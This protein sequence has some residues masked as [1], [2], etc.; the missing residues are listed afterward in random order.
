MKFKK[1]NEN[2]ILSEAI[3]SSAPKWLRPAI[4]NSFKSKNSR[5]QFGSQGKS[6][7]PIL[8]SDCGRPP[9][10]WDAKAKSYL[11]RGIDI[12]SRLAKGMHFSGRQLWKSGNN[13]R[14]VL[15]DSDIDFS[16]A[17]FIHDEPPKN[18]ADQRLK[19]HDK[20]QS[21]ILLDFGEDTNGNKHEQIY[22]PGLN[23]KE[24]VNVSSWNHP[25]YDKTFS[26]V[27]YKQLKPYIKDFCY[28][29]MTDPNS[30][31]STVKDVRNA[32]GRIDAQ[33]GSNYINVR[34]DKP[35]LKKLYSPAWLPHGYDIDKSG[36]IIN[37]NRYKEILNKN[38]AK[39]YTKLLDELYDDLC[40]IKSEI[41]TLFTTVDI[42]GKKSSSS[43]LS[44]I[45]NLTYDFQDVSDYYNSLL[46]KIDSINNNT[47]NSEEE[48][49]EAIIGL[50]GTDADH[51]YGYGCYKPVRD[52]V[53]D[54][55]KKLNRYVSTIIDW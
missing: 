26:Y 48:K 20:Y 38:R 19:D 37:P 25:L 7:V 12:N 3:S 1:L 43:M 27:S 28:I 14:R 11:N 53:N 30:K 21:F 33:N 34:F 23:D 22:A 39:N 17:N 13:L 2:R 24:V 31:E 50:F 49:K 32:N 40:S 46:S 16:R 41:A 35:S 51:Y 29:D 45:R 36:Y 8:G 4:I 15:C 55:L 6:R 54:L 44:D 9:I 5:N 42:D 47:N 10:D 18:G 52:G